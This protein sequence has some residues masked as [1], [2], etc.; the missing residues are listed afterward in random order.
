MKLNHYFRGVN[1]KAKRIRWPDSKT[2]W[3][4]VGIILLITV[5]AALCLYFFDFIA[6]QI[7]KAFSN[8]YPK[9]S[10]S[11]SGAAAMAILHCL[12]L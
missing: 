4:N 6:I 5:V 7:N 1:E 8:A 10:S 12:G 9:N 11:S 3:K 2:L